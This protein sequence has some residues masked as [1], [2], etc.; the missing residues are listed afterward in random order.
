MCLIE[1]FR[2]ERGN[3]EKR[4]RWKMKVVVFLCMMLSVGKYL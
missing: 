3:L 4:L 1:G 2:V